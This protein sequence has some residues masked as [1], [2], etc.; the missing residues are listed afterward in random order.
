MKRTMEVGERGKHWRDD[1][2]WKPDLPLFQFAGSLALLNA[3][4]GKNPAIFCSS[5]PLTNLLSILTF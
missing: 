4:W 1:Q 5:G 2:D 3:C